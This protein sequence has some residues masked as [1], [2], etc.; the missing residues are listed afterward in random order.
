MELRKDYIL[1]EW[2]IISENRNK[3]PKQFI[4]KEEQELD[5][6]ICF[7]CP[8]NEEKTPKEISRITKNNKWIIR[9]IPNK[10][11]SVNKE[12]FAEIKT[13]NTFF[14]YSNAY[15][16]HEVIIETNSHEKQLWDLPKEHLKLILKTYNQRIIELHKDSNVK[17]VCVIKNHGKDGGTSLKHSHSQVIAYN[18]IPASITNKIKS[19]KKFDNCPMCS[20]INIEKDSDRRVF[21]NNTFIA[22]TPYAS[23]FNFEIIII[24]KNHKETLNDLTKEELDDFSDIWEKILKKLKSLNVSFNHYIHYSPKENN[25]HLSMHICPRIAKFAGFELCSNTIINTVS[26]ESA[27]KFYRE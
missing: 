3:R 6:K 23:K 16:N 19:Y 20:I 13:D 21:E 22:F 14:T 2:V 5:D 1:D 12:S 4:Q 26:P 27:A 15:G 17:Y 11:P 24:P 18:N 7:F 10:F 25:L 8:G 9:T